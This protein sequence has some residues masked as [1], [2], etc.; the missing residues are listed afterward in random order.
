MKKINTA[1]KYAT[2]ISLLVNILGIILGSLLTDINNALS[3]YK[4]VG[5]V[6][7]III[8]IPCF[9]SI[10]FTFQKE[11]LEHNASLE[12]QLNDTQA[13]LDSLKNKTSTVTAFKE[14]LSEL[15]YDGPYG[16]TLYDQATNMSDLISSY[17]S[18]I[19]YTY[20]TFKYGSWFD[21]SK[22]KPT[23]ANIT[24]SDDFLKDVSFTDNEQPIREELI[25]DWIAEYVDSEANEDVNFSD[26]YFDLVKE[27]TGTKMPVGKPHYGFLAEID[28]EVLEDFLN[29]LNARESLFSD[30]DN[31]R[32]I[33]IE[34]Y[35]F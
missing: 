22:M 6:F 4:E 5:P 12:D 3:D 18:H 11:L 26:A 30:L 19:S 1:F 17:K 32:L 16:E 35:I 7:V 25:K 8:F 28:E 13:I 15:V 21:G 27:V 34:R 24:I 23:S 31:T 9:F 14:Q 20:N 10:F 33:R 29:S 2:A